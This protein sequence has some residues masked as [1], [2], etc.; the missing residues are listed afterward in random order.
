MKYCFDDLCRGGG[1]LKIPGESPLM[2]CDGCGELVSFDGC[3]D[4]FRCECIEDMTDQILMDQ[5]DDYR[6]GDEELT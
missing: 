5:Y 1:C 4:V 2:K 6:P 3:S